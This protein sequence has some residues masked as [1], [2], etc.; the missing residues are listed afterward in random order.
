MEVLIKT[1]LFEDGHSV[2]LLPL[3]KLPISSQEGNREVKSIDLN[4]NHAV[5]EEHP[6]VTL[7][8]HNQ[9]IDSDFASEEKYFE[10]LRV[11]IQKEAYQSGYSEGLA[12]VKAKYDEKFER[13]DSLIS[14]INEAL[15]IYL[16]EKEFMIASI[17]FESVCKILGQ[18]LT[19]KEE[20]IT[21][22]LNSIAGI[23]KEKIREVFISQSDFDAIS[24]LSTAV[25]AD[26]VVLNTRID[27]SLFKVDAS[28]KL[29]GCK[30]KLVEGFLDATIDSQLLTLSKSLT[31]KAHD[32]AL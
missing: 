29:G 2:F 30:V 20:S 22:V 3:E 9:D 28:I 19:D 16:K 23:D 11:K 32:L 26:E 18:T 25:T 12:G 15:P 27:Q 31:A 10:E 17:V 4:E 8:S 1:A 7:D 5:F 14:S 6:T 21:V 24:D 13:I